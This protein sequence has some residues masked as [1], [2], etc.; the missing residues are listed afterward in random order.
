MEGLLVGHTDGDIITGTG[1]SQA[2]LQ[3]GRVRTSLVQM[4]TMEN[5]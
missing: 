3:D 2:I 5:T 1:T 4:F